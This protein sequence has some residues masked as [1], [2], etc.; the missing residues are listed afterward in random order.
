MES[1]NRKIGT[2]LLLAIA[3]WDTVP[4]NQSLKSAFENASRFKAG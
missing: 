3:F 1:Y 2:L 4:P